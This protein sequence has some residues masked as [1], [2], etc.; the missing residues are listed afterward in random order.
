MADR[1]QD[2]PFPNDDAYGRGDGQHASAR[3][4]SDP[5]A[6]LARLIGQTDPFGSTGRAN[7]VPPRSAAHDPY[8]A[9]VEAVEDVPVSRPPWMQHAARQEAPPQDYYSQDQ[10]SQGH[11]GQDHADQG[12]AGQD[13]ADQ[14]YPEDQPVQG[15]PSAEHPLRRYAAQQHAE[16]EPDYGHAQPFAD[17]GQPLD[18]AR[19]DD[20]L[21]GQP[22][23]GVPAVQYGQSYSDDPY[24]YQSDY[25]EAAEEEAP[26]RRGGLATVVVVLALA[27]VGTGA[28]FAY[29]TYAGSPRSGEPPII[30]ADTTPTKVIPAS[31]DTSGKQPDRL[32]PG[33]GTEKIVPREEAP[34][35]VKANAGGPA[36]RM[37]FP[38]LNQ[39]ANPPSVASVTPNAPPPAPGGNNGTMPNSEPHRIKT[40][41]VRGDQP[42][43]A[44]VP[45]NAQA[46]AA[47]TAP[48]APKPARTAATPRTAPSAANANASANAPLSLSP[49]AAA[50]PPVPPAPVAAEPRTRVATNAPTQI[51]PASA[52]ASGAAPGGGYLVQVSSQKNEADAQASYRVLQGKFPSVLGSHSP[53]IKRADLG[54]KGVYYRAMVGP[55]GSPDEAS[56]FCGSLKSAGGQCV[57]QRN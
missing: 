19:Y 44:A 12:H 26:K 6:E 41:S 40:F 35:D 53:V 52:P 15:Y 9:P 8:D 45:V 10:A 20:A 13:Y 47:Q 37:V 56:Q 55:F 34:V 33:D 4:E 39:N 29:R 11:A 30:K 43:G 17:D 32:P 25:D 51:A 2:R 5:L 24:A 54:E 57:I 14:D 7:Q 3:S 36:P 1:Y 27:V 49:Q 18:P 28:A 22:D 50:Q 46:P 16:P 42:D 23:P 38:P 31:T 48:A 21:F